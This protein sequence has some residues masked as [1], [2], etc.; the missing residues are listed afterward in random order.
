MEVNITVLDINDHTPM[1][2]NPLLSTRIPESSPPGT[3]LTDFNVTDSD[4]GDLGVQGV[5]FSIVAG[6]VCQTN[7][8]SGVIGHS[9]STPGN[10]DLFSV[11][12]VSGILK[13]EAL[14]DRDVGPACQ[15]LSI[16]ASD[17]A[18]ENT[19]SNVTEVRALT[20]VHSV[21]EMR[22]TMQIEVCLIDQNDNC[23]NFTQPS[24]SGQVCSK[25]W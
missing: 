6:T 2:L 13:T 5:R 3:V 19:L 25:L 12:P 17:S 7:P 15:F 16:Q 21:S 4:S 10:T 20:R 8:V 18:G 9:L 22:Y 11:N 14:L 1:F 24:F 23:P